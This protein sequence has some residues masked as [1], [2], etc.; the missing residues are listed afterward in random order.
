MIEFIVL[1]RADTELYKI[2]F[3]FFRTSSRD[4]W[5]EVFT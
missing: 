1:I 2:D 3:F 5:V 4:S